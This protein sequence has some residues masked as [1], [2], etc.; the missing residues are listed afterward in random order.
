MR[1][2]MLKYGFIAAAIMTAVII[3]PFAIRDPENLLE[4]MGWGEVV[5]YTTMIVAMS[6]IFF[7]LKEHRE[8]NLG[9]VMRFRTGLLTGLAVTLV[10]ALLFGLATAGLYAWMGPER[11]DEFMHAYIRY[12]AG[13]DASP[14]ELAEAM[15][16]Y[17]AQ[18][19]LW[20]NPFFQGFVMFG[21][22]VPIGLVISLISAAVLRPRASSRTISPE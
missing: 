18:R 3:L 9:G 5:G 7:A 17:E 21:T 10:A 13:A 1:T 16:S 8:R 6:L 4:N 14:Q 19:N 22:I 15:A 20:L 12:S 2:I 11:T